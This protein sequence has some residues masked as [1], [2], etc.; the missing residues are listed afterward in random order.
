MK[1]FYMALHRSGHFHSPRAWTRAFDVTK[2]LQSQPRSEEW[3]IVAYHASEASLAM[4]N[5]WL[6]GERPATPCIPPV[7]MR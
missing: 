7:V 3:E 2:F 4:G 6:A 1:T 5:A